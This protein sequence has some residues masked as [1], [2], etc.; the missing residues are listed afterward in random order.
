MYEFTKQSMW[1]VTYSFHNKSFRRLF[2]I[3]AH[4]CVLFD[5]SLPSPQLW[6]MQ[7]VELLEALDNDGG[8]APYVQNTR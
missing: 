3:L 1:I 7:N 5:T 6:L 4:V 8:C 2:W